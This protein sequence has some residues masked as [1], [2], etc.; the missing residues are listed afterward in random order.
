[1]R[2]TRPFVIGAVLAATT[3]LTGCAN[4][5]GTSAAPSGTPAPVTSTPAGSSVPA[6]PA[7]PSTAPASAAPTGSTGTTPAKPTTR[8]KATSDLSGLRIT[9]I[10]AGKSVLIDVAGDDAD[11]FLQVGQGGVDFTGT[12]RTDATMMALYPAAVSAKNR[13]VIKPPFWNEE[14]GG[15]YCVADTAGAAL[16]LEN[17]QDGK[18][19]QVW[20]VQLAGDSGLFELHGAYGVIGVKNGRITASGDRDTGLQVLPYAQ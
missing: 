17:C 15:G 2:H 10:K 8:A 19:S 16:K 4:S 5:Q 20:R 12:E 11:R 9:G 6:V 14:V 13:V 1:M 3:L 18:A 7:E